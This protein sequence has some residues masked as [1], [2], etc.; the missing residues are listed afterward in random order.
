MLMRLENPTA[1]R[2]IHKR[3]VFIASVK[4]K[5][6]SCGGAT[7]EGH[8][9]SRPEKAAGFVSLLFIQTK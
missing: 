4:R 8:W 2:G 1:H 5:G 9:H 7:A 3:S 6:F